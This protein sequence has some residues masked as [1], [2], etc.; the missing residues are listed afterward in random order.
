MDMK[1]VY[2]ELS[3]TDESLKQ[4]TVSLKSLCSGVRWFLNGTHGQNLLSLWL[5][6]SYSNNHSFIFISFAQYLL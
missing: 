3:N 1:D 6:T 2:N 5:V 4:G